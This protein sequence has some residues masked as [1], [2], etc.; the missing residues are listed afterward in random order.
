MPALLACWEDGGQHRE[1][2]WYI[3]GPQ[4]NSSGLARKFIQVCPQVLEENSS[5]LFGHPMQY[6]IVSYNYSLYFYQ[7]IFSF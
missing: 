1:S 5:E 7:N 2:A 3:A 6:S 4:I